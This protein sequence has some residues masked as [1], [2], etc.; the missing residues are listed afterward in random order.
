[1]EA[2][3]Q[4]NAKANV[5]F[6]YRL[7]GEGWP[8]PEDFVRAAREL[9]EAMRVRPD[10]PKIV[11]KPN[12]V[13]G[14]APDSGISVHPAFVAG[15]ID[16]FGSLGYGPERIAV[17]EGGSSE[18]DPDMR[19]HFGQAGYEEYVAS[20]GVRLVDLNADSHVRVPIPEGIV[21]KEMPIASTIK[22][23]EAYFVDVAKLKSHNLAITT[24]T[25]KN[26]QG[27]VVP[28]GERHMCT[29]FPRYEGDRGGRGSEIS[30]DNKLDT[31]E[32]WANKILDIYLAAKPD[33]NLVEGI[34]G[35]DGT[36]FHRGDNLPTRTAIGGSNPVA[37]DTLASFIMGFDPA[38]LTYL[39]EAGKR[40][41]GPN[42]V[43]E[44]EIYEVTEG[45]RVKPCD[46]PEKLVSPRKF[47]VTL[48]QR[49]RY[50]TLE[51]VEYTEAEPESFG[52]PGR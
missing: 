34:V 41:L 2:H 5:V 21:F 49:W 3:M 1:M 22:D 31:H 35:R 52:R 9:M 50:A 39:R 17:G 45:G 42:Q 4:W 11:I 37:V 8:A 46:D 43:S 48:A 51:D 13:V 6:A 27:I 16:Y 33:L 12:V 44:L 23:P 29:P 15:L 7:P 19:L 32:R 26:L 36:G 28:I 24:L 25:I 20:K 38:K 14:V 40:S 18:E 47:R 30:P 10:R